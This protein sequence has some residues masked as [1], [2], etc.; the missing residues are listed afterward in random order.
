MLE[1]DSCIRLFV[2]AALMS[3]DCSE[4]IDC[5]GNLSV[6]IHRHSFSFSPHAYLHA[7]TYVH[8]HSFLY[9]TFGSSV[10]I[11][12]IHPYYFDLRIYT[13]SDTTLHALTFDSSI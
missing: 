6:H 10:S 12:C 11:H 13:I 9:V 8:T 3:L 2:T 4:D 5:L 1:S 7:R